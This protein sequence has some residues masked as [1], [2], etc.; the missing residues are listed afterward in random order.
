MV[1]ARIALEDGSIGEDGTVHRPTPGLLR[2]KELRLVRYLA[3]RP[4]ITVGRAELYESVWGYHR[5]TRSRTLDTTVHRVR[6]AIEQDPAAPRHLVT[7]AGVGY[8]FVPAAFDG[9]LL[10]SHVRDGL[11]AAL[12]DRPVV[13]WGP[14]GCGKSHWLRAL[15][16]PG[17]DDAADD[18]PT[19]PLSTRSR[20]P[21]QQGVRAVEVTPLSAAAARVLL[22]NRLDELGS[23][24]ACPEDLEVYDGLPA[25]LLAAAERASVFGRFSEP[26]AN[27]PLQQ[28][29]AKL[30]AGDGALGALAAL[31]GTPPAAFVGAVLGDDRLLEWL[32]RG[33]VRRQGEAVQVLAHVR[34]AAQA[35]PVLLA[36]LQAA[37]EAEFVSAHR[38]SLGITDRSARERARLLAPDVRAPTSLVRRARL[39]GLPPPAPHPDELGACGA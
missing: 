17:V 19:M 8:R 24:V 29:F 33:L 23:D 32:D 14:P 35:D 9:G 18:T 6:E 26:G 36:R 37:L 4:G 21:R 27:D 38:P 3:M 11:R 31:T 20:R 25:A 39:L 30:V 7:D 22:T 28:R 10:E 2:A 13:L 5:E 1:N 34:R 15:G 16:R 12:G